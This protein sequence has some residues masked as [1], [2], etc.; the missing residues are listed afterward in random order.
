MWWAFRFKWQEEKKWNDSLLHGV[1]VKP[2]LLQTIRKRQY[3]CL[4]HLR[5]YDLK[6]TE[7][8]GVSGE[9]FDN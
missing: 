2:Y 4:H 1:T 3:E 9:K 8:L 6:L 5:K 7:I